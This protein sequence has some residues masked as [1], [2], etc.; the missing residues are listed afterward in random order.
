MTDEI[1][2]DSELVQ[3][4]IGPA[5]PHGGRPAKGRERAHIDDRRALVESMELAGATVRAIA[6]RVKV[7]VSTVH[8]DLTAVRRARRARLGA[9][10]LEAQRDLELDRL[11]QQRLWLTRL[12][13][14]GSVGA[15]RT[16][17]R[18]SESKRRLLGLDAPPRIVIQS[19]P[20]EALATGVTDET[21]RALTAGIRPEDVGLPIIDVEVVDDDD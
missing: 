20:F 9:V 4:G 6:E 3:H 17:I 16:L 2:P 21:L 11:E 5:K 1:G 10:D 14:G 7:S 19:D 15:N 8:D 12:A 18:L 13:Q